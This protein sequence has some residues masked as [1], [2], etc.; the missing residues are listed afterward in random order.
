MMRLATF[1]AIAMLAAACGCLVSSERVQLHKRHVSYEAAKGASAARLTKIHTEA[2]KKGLQPRGAKLRHEFG[3]SPV[4]MYNL[5]GGG[6]YV[7]AVDIGTP[8]Q[9]FAVIYDTGS[10]N[11]WV[12]STDCTDFT[13]SP[14]CGIQRR[15]DNASSSTYNPKCSVYPNCGLLLP[16]GSG[17]VWGSVAQDTVRV[18]PFVLPSTNVGLVA[19]EP[20]PLD[21]WSCNV[22]PRQWVMNGI[23][24]L[25]TDLI[26]MPFFSFLPS[27]YTEMWSRGLI[28]QHLY[29]V[30]LSNVGNSSGS[31]IDFGDVNLDGTEGKLITVGQSLLNLELGYYAV[32]VVGLD[33]AGEPLSGVNSG[34]VGVIDTGTTL[35]AIP[36]QPGLVAATNVSAD[37][38]NLDQL[39]TLTFRISVSGDGGASIPFDLTPQMYTYIEELK[40]GGRSCQNGVFNFDAG[41]GLLP[42]WILGDRF[43]TSFRSV[44]RKDTYQMAF[45]RNKG[46][47]PK[48]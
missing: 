17:T 22:S 43:I 45:A 39:P 13:T 48:K 2:F 11:L 47:G 33:V 15:F 26:A 8:P 18:G 36:N 30:F 7:G 40:G 27:P 23:M 14:C 16:Y 4:P 28:K 9:R 42:L 24:G 3:S 29:T 38:S 35:L 19:S 37:C 21:E 41:E 44:F 25:A 46:T 10:S 20:G 1:A 32:N 5:I 34:T 31:F 12:P 6:A